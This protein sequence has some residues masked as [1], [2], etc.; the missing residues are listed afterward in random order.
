MAEGQDDHD[1]SIAQGAQGRL[2]THGW[3]IA[4]SRVTL[5]DFSKLWVIYSSPV[6]DNHCLCVL[7][8]NSGSSWQ[9]IEDK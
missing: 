4:L 7:E 8:E 9:D 6:C 1:T 3:L 2:M 5:T